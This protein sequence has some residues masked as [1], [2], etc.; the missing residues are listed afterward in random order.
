MTVIKRI[1]FIWFIV[2]AI[3]VNM[4]V[5]PMNTTFAAGQTYYISSSSGDDSNNGTSASTP[6]KSFAK[7]NTVVFQPSDQ[8]LLKSG[9][10]WTGTTF[11]PHGN[12]TAANPILISSY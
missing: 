12:G 6:W 10:T 11:Y 8:I 2:L 4:L 7:A 9:D 5:M 1:K 3:L